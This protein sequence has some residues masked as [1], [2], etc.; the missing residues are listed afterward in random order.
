MSRA[1]AAVHGQF[2]RAVIYRLNR[3]FNIHAHREGHLIFHLSGDRADVLVSGAPCR[4]TPESVVAVSPWEPHN[5]VPADLDEGSTFFVLYVNPDWFA[6]GIGETRLRFG[7]SEF[8]RTPALDAQIRRVSGLVCAGQRLTAL[9]CE[10]RGLIQAC[11]EETWRQ[12]ETRRQ[13]DLGEGRCGSGQAIDFRV[14]KSM[15][16]MEDSLGANIELDAVA[17]GAGLSRPHFYKLFRTQT[18]LTPNLYVNTLRMEHAI[19]RLVASEIPV[20]DIGYDLG[21]SSQSGFTRFFAANVGMAP[22]Q[23]RRVAHVL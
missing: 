22:T 8:A 2:G 23:Y 15:R 21:F 11:C 12:E 17:R 6:H 5:F 18:G 20:A 10:L 9:D 1:V 16:L 13:M 7:R 4:A 3:P 14:R 19:E